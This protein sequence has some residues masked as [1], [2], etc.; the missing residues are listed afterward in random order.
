M[1]RFRR[2]SAQTTAVLLALAQNPRV[3]RHGYDLCQE[4]GLKPGTLYP[5]L[6]RLADRGHLETTWESDAPPGRPTRHMYRLT[7]QGRSL[8]AELAAANKRASLGKRVG[9][10]PQTE[11]V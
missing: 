6:I 4:L 9:L 10:R 11:G 5:I 3:W 1:E 2:P 8:V 7:G